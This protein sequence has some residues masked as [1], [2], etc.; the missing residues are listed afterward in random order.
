MRAI[1]YAPAFKRDFKRVKATSRHGKDIDSLLAALLA[2]LA[3]DK[4]LPVSNRD[5]A[6]VGD[7]AGT[8]NAN[9]SLTCC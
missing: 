3:A 4:S 7:W 1:E 6:L 9:S 5:H 8:A 2:M